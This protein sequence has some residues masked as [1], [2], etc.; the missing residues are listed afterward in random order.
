MPSRGYALCCDFQ[1]I[2]GFIA[3]RW[4]VTLLSGT[5]SY[6]YPLFF[7]T[8][9]WGININYIL[10]WCRWPIRLRTCWRAF[11]IFVDDR[12]G[13]RTCWWAFRILFQRHS[14]RFPAFQILCSI[15]TNVFWLHV[16]GSITAGV[17]LSADVLDRGGQRTCCSFYSEYFLGGGQNKVHL[18]GIW[19]KQ[20]EG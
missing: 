9:S 5:S 2:H 17:L 6:L 11:H 12:Q 8:H 4:N 10:I 3:R 1:C 18:A 7:R 19:P 13:F 16:A 20:G 15:T 14:C